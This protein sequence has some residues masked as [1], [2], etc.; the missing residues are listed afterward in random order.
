MFSKGPLIDAHRFGYGVC[1]V[2]GSLPKL[3]F[4]LPRGT[5]RTYSDV[6]A[7]F[8]VTGPMNNDEKNW[9]TDAS[10]MITRSLRVELA[11]ALTVMVMSSWP[12]TNPLR[13]AVASATVRAW[14]RS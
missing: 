2:T 3:L 10:V 1:G 8:T 13:C 7:R 11:L 4:G 6:A 12:L 14:A 9:S 5:G